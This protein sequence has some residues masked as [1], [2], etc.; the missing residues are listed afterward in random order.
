MGAAPRHVRRLARSPAGVQPRRATQLPGEQ[1]KPVNRLALVLKVT[2]AAGRLLHAGAH[3]QVQPEHHDRRLT[4]R[5]TV[6]S[7]TGEKV[8]IGIPGASEHP[9]FREE[10]YL[11][12]SR[13]AGQG[14]RGPARPRGRRPLD[15]RGP[16]SVARRGR[17]GARPAQP[18]VARS[19]VPVHNCIPRKTASR[20]NATPDPPRCEK[21]HAF[22]ALV[23]V[24]PITNRASRTSPP[25]RDRI[26]RSAMDEQDEAGPSPL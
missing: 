14:E 12:I 22:R 24:S 15:R 18:A 2:S 11:E 13:S 10:V 1:G 20:D 19:Y 9:G 5:S 4:S 17:R 7:I 6:L 23:G 26:A 16:R 8:R 21:D 3:P 25:S